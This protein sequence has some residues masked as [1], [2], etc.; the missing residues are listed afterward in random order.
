MRVDE[1]TKGPT[2]GIHGEEEEEWVVLEK[3]PEMFS[4]A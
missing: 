2:E 3:S 4:V 1:R